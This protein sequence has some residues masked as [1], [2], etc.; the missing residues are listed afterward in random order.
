MANGYDV[1]WVMNITDVGH[2][3]SDE[4]DG[5]DK[6]EKG[7]R[8]EGKTA[9]EVADFYTQDF[10]QSLDLLNIS[11][12]RENLKKA[13]DAIPEQIQLVQTLEQKGYT[14]VID[15]GVYFDTTKLDDY[16]KLGKIDLT[17]LRAGERV[18]FNEQKRATT[19]FALWKFTPKGQKRDMEWDSPWG[20]G[21]P[22]WHI[23][24]SALAMKHLA[25]TIDIHAGGIDHIPVHHTNEIAQSEAATGKPFANTW[26]HSNFLTVDGVKL[27]K[28]LGNS[29]TLHDLINKGFHSLDYRFFALQSHYRTQANFTWDGL[30]AARVRRHTLCS[31]ADIRYQD[32]AIRVDVASLEGLYTDMLTAL[33]DDLDTPAALALLSQLDSLL[34]GSQSHD[35]PSARSDDGLTAVL[36]K[37]ENLLG[38]G[39]LDGPD[40]S[41][42]QKS[43]LSDRAKARADKN[44]GKSDQ[45]RDTLNDQG[46]E[47]RDTDHGQ[48]WSRSLPPTAG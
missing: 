31:L 40:I 8:R 16:G 15:D 13:T 43:L 41:D 3:V 5:E 22:G 12:P 1:N 37:I 19:D 2:L 24:C 46:V 17:A 26:V 30:E 25:E 7:A 39:L 42:E 47:I 33:S 28:S 9:W 14:Y 20:R 36:K 18:A 11:V 23:E 10:V 32:A 38:I 29:Y 34:D 4:D 35:H 45:I 44:W 21:F 6:M 48:I 27:S